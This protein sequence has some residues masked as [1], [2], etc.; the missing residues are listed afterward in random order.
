MKIGKAPT[1]LKKA[2]SMCKSK[3]GVL[4]TKLL[5]L[6]SLRR[7]MAMAAVI[8]HKIQVLI[9]PTDQAGG[10]NRHNAKNMT[11]IH[12]GHIIDLSH[13]LDLFDQEENGATGLPNWMFHHYC[14]NTEEYEEDVQ[15]P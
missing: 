2:V 13:Q 9:V 1:L 4:K 6:A 14:C 12:D 8:S 7:R 3:T 11:A 5:L 15:E 10:D